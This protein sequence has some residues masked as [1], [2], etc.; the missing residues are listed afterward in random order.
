MLGRSRGT[1]TPLIDP[2]VSRI[3]C[4]VMLDDNRHVLVD[5]DSESGTFVNGKEIERHVLQS[6]DLIRIGSQDICFYDSDDTEDHP[7]TRPRNWVSP[8]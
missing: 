6:G 3:H 2:H 8:A 4:E 1:D 5:H 7:S